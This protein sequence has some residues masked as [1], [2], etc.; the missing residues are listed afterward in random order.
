MERVP[1]LAHVLAGVWVEV[2]DL[3]ED[4]VALTESLGPGCEEGWIPYAGC[5]NL[6]VPCLVDCLEG[7]GFTGELD[8][9]LVERI[10]G[11]LVLA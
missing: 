3:G 5:L 11:R 1:F 6:W 4:G 7:F 8:Q 2:L 10:A 9:R